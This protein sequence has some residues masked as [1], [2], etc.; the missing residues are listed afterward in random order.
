MAN[1][2]KIMVQTNETMSLAAVLWQKEYGTRG[3]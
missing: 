3:N 2:I 1:C